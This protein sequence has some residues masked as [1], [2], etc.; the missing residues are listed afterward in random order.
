VGWT[1]VADQGFA[2]FVLQFFEAGGADL[3]WQCFGPGFEVAR[4]FQLQSE[5]N[6]AHGWYGRHA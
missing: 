5:H 1:H 2:G 6:F 3:D 4:A